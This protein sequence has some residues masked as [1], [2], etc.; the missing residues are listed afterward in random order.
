MKKMDDKILKIRWFLS[1][2][3]EQA[4]GQIL[5]QR[6]LEQERIQ[7]IPEDC[8]TVRRLEEDDDWCL[9]PWAAL[10]DV[11]LGRCRC[12]RSVDSVESAASRSSA[13]ARNLTSGPRKKAFVVIG[14]NTAF[15]S[16]RRRIR[17]DKPGCIVIR[18][19]IGRSVSRNGILD[20]AIDTEEASHHDILR[21]LLHGPGPHRRLPRAHC[22]T[23]AFFSTA[24]QEW[25]ADFYMKV[26]DDVH[27]NLGALAS[28]LANYRSRSRTYLGCMKSVPKSKYYEPEF[29]K[30]GNRGN[31]YFRHASGQIYVI[32]QDLAAY[33]FINRDILHKYANEDVSLGSWLI[34]LDVDY[35]NDM[36]LCCR[37]L[38]DCEK[39]AQTGDPCVAS[40]DWNCSGICRPVERMASVHAMCGEA[41]GA[42][43]ST[44]I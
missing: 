7:I 40:F 17:S 25:D 4:T 32:S 36:S 11:E 3:H 41:D 27:V 10:S 43:W 28:T 33:I 31:R 20:Q 8:A 5:L 39:K 1:I 2:P 14:I 34:G 12:F 35:T 19:M 29:W 44:F 37:T 26:D 22:E 6:R 42:I 24:V 30:F 15:S 13:L 9:D 18:F 16:R 23:K 38:P 21:L